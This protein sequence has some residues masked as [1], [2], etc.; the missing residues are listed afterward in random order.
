MMMIRYMCINTHTQCNGRS[1]KDMFGGYIRLYL[2]I[3][4]VFGEFRCSNAIQEHSMKHYHPVHWN[5]PN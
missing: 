1:R 3:L 4:V 5:L 2:Y